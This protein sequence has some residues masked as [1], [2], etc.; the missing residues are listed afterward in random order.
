MKVKVYWNFHKKLFS[1]QHKGLVIDHS[2][3]LYLMNV[4]F[5]VG[6]GGRARVIREESKNVHAY[7]VGELMS[8]S[9]KQE[10]ALDHLFQTC[11]DQATYDPYKY[12]SFVRVS[13]E[14]PVFQAS[15][16]N[17]RTVE[18]RAKIFIFSSVESNKILNCEMV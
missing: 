1:V 5:L 15:F 3:N 17:L 13:D 6:Q 8:L 7:A 10:S 12:E 9:A 4:D 2:E 18:L 14:S 11:G 16:V